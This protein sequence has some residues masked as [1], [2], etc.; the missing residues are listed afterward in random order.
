MF[1][2]IDG[3]LLEYS[4]H[5]LML[6][7]IPDE[8]QIE[9][10]KVFTINRYEDRMTSW[11]APLYIREHLVDRLGKV[12]SFLNNIYKN[13][14]YVSGAPGCGKT[15]FFWMLAG[16]LMKQEKRVLFIQYRLHVGCQIWVLEGSVRKRVT[17]PPIDFTS[18]KGV[19][20]DLLQ[21][22]TGRQKFDVC[23]C[24]GVRSK[25][26]TCKGLLALLKGLT[27]NAEKH[28]ISKSI[29]VTS[30]QFSIPNSE[31][32]A[33]DDFMTIDSWREKDYEKAV[34]TPHGPGRDILL[35]DW[36]YLKSSPTVADQRLTGD[37]KLRQAVR[38]KYEYAGGCARYMFDESMEQLMKV[39]DDL[40]RKVGNAN[41]SAFAE[42]TMSDSAPDAVNS[43]MQQFSSE[44]TDPT[45]MCTPVSKFVLD[46]AYDKCREALTGAVKSVARITRNGSL[47]GW[48]FELSQKDIIHSVLKAN[49]ASLEANRKAAEENRGATNVLKAVK[50]ARLEFVP[51]AEAEFDGTTII[52]EGSGKVVSGTVIWFVKPNQE[53]FDVAF[54]WGETLVTLKFTV[55]AKHS[56]GLQYVKPLRTEINDNPHS[57]KNRQQSNK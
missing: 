35:N 31:K 57:H 9:E 46:M 42:T 25:E 8:N 6:G 11:V 34:L 36:N 50:N 30:L 3:Y 33:G 24:D 41:W 43:L 2:V 5:P 15:C 47:A 26:E 20:S 49:L 56:L 44:G 22:R 7:E 14:L 27:G 32:S 4:E 54:Y 48:A 40:F 13:R 39:F 45:S 37:D 53:L 55:A 17:S 16:I 52:I 19:V 28:K 21:T 29:L 10:G 1:V 38:Q 51:L 23:I 12:R 18:V